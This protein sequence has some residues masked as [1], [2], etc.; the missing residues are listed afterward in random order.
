MS[1]AGLAL[2][3]TVGVGVLGCLAVISGVTQIVWDAMHQHAKRKRTS[4]GNT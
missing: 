4:R 2:H 1:A 3:F